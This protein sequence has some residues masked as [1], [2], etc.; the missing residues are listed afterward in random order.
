MLVAAGWQAKAAGWFTKEIAPGVTAVVA[1]S[2]ASKH[3]AAGT[4]SVTVHVGLRDDPTEHVVEE[5]SGSS[6]PRY[7]GRTWVTALGYL[8]PGSSFF[9]GERVFNE[10]NATS[11]AEELALSLAEHAE[12]RL[13][14]IAGD[15]SELTRLAKDSVSSVGRSGLCRVATLLNRTQGLEAASTYV[16]QRLTELGDRTDHA[17]EL[18][19]EVAPRLL[20]VLG[21][22]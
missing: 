4:A 10:R 13:L 9:E 16:A 11:Q 17:A 5:L 22:K 15:P 2:A 7:Q 1:V 20:A 3:H 6:T 12:P 18:E 8:L 21:S 19:R 14:R